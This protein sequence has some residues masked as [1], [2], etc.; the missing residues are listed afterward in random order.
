MQKRDIPSWLLVAILSAA[1]YARVLFP[2]QDDWFGDLMKLHPA[3][4]L[5]TGLVVG[6][7]LYPVV[8]HFRNVAK[9]WR[10]RVNGPKDDAKRRL[11]ELRRQHGQAPPPT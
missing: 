7:L 8:Q 9:S 4:P 5:W 10:N 1:I 11:D 3:I 2:D 6:F